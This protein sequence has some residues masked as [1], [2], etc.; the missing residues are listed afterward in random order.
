MSTILTS[1]ALCW[2]EFGAIAA[3]ADQLR[4]LEKRRQGVATLTSMSPGELEVAIC[5]TDRSGHVAA[6]GQIGR[7]LGVGL[8]EPYW[9]SVAFRVPF[10]PTELPA[11][12]REFAALVEASIA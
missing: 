6:E 10:C 11:L 9:S 12:V 5:S 2:V 4:S 1:E 7:W 8:G 3:F